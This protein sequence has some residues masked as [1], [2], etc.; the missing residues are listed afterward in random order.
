M[1]RWVLD[2]NVLI[3]ALLTPRSTSAQVL[4]QALSACGKLLVSKATLAELGEVLSRPKFDRYVSR[5][6]RNQFLIDL[7]PVVELVPESSPIRACRDPKDDKLLE[8]A[9]HGQADALITGDADLLALNTFHWVSIVA[10]ARFVAD[11]PAGRPAFTGYVQEPRARYALR[12]K[13]G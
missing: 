9:V 8:V 3:S 2:T 1:R 7:M 11:I 6:T 4:A 10:P 13:A 12:G 5:N